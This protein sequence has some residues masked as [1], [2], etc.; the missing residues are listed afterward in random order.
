ML[1]MSFVFVLTSSGSLGLWLLVFHLQGICLLLGVSDVLWALVPSV[2][3]DRNSSDPF[4]C[5]IYCRGVG[6]L[7]LI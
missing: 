6:S 2:L 3:Q 1:V 5:N 4:T 7:L